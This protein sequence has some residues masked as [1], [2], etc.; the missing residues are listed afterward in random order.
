MAVEKSPR[1]KVVLALAF[2]SLDSVRRRDSSAGGKRKGG[3]GSEA[4]GGEGRLV[5]LVVRG[6]DW[7]GDAGSVSDGREGMVGGLLP[8]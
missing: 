6:V 8:A 4:E 7:G 3:S 5:L 1:V 2:R